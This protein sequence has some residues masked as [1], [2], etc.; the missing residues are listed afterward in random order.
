M[1]MQAFKLGL[2]MSQDD[3]FV[4]VDAYTF[5]G[6]SAQRS[7]HR[8]LIDVICKANIQSTFISL[9]LSASIMPRKSQ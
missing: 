1:Q 5:S 7:D 8:L 2:E 9:V 4:A 6:Q 3:S